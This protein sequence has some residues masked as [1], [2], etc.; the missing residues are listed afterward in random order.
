MSKSTTYSPGGSSNFLVDLIPA[1][2]R[3]QVYA[4]F[5]LIGALLA[6]VTTVMAAITQSVPPEWLIGLTVGYNFLTPFFSALASA[7]ATP[8]GSE[9]ANAAFAYD[10][11][12]Y[13]DHG[14]YETD[15]ESDGTEEFDEVSEDFDL[16][17]LPSDEPEGW[18]GDIEDPVTDDTEEG[19]NV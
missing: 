17:L 2:Q 6:L 15:Y 7:N 14:D 10:D 8:T 11:G 3:K 13:S 12:L 5:G 4:V 19:R 18:V 9:A 16:T 1:H